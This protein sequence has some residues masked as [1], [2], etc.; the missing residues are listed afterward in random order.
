MLQPLRHIL[1]T[2]PIFFI[3]FSF[4]CEII[5][6]EDDLQQILYKMLE[7]PD[8][9]IFADTVTFVWE[10]DP[11][12]STRWKLISHDLS[13]DENTDIIF[14][15]DSIWSKTGSHVPTIDTLQIVRLLTGNYTFRMELKHPELSSINRFIHKFYIRTRST[16]PYLYPEVTSENDIHSTDEIEIIF[17]LENIDPMIAAFDLV[18]LYDDKYL[19]FKQCTKSSNISNPYAQ[20]LTH[21]D[22][23]S[24]SISGYPNSSRKLSINSAFL[25]ITNSTKSYKKIDLCTTL[26]SAQKAGTTKIY[27][28]KYRLFDDTEDHDSIKFYIQSDEINLNILE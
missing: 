14:S 19:S 12:L 17:N 5:E 25:K 15:Q 10:K 3:T 1:I 13:S 2:I 8:D 20:L 28:H 26:F 24:E 9:S 18:L 11:F 16:E 7:V 4:S 27:L 21:E 22:T 6:P 23:T